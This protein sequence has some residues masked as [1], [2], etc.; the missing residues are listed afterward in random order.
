[1]SVRGRL[2]AWSTVVV[3]VLL[4]AFSTG[5]LLLARMELERQVDRQLLEDAQAVAETAPAG[6]GELDELGEH[7]V[8][9]FAV[10]QHDQL[11]FAS[12][13]WKAAGPP[14]QSLA[15]WSWSDSAG[16]PY[17]GHT[18]RMG[19]TQILVM[20]NVHS[21]A[22]TLHAMWSMWLTSIPLGLALSLIGGWFL[23]G[24]L[25]EPVRDLAARL[26]HISP[27]YLAERLVVGRRHDEF[28]TL[29]EAINETLARLEVAFTRLS[30]FTAD[31]SHQLRTPL[32]ALRS[33]GEVAL[34]AP[35]DEAKSREVIGSMLEETRR[36]S[37]LVDSLLVL[38]R[39]DA[40]QI[41]LARVPTPLSELV[42]DVVQQLR[43]LAD[44]K[45][46]TLDAHAEN[47]ETV[48]LDPATM[49]HALLNVLDNAI[50]YTP[51]GGRIAVH[52]RGRRIT[53]Q[54]SGP[55]IA[56]EHQARIFDRFYRVEATRNLVPQGSGLGLAIA[57]WVI[58][59]HG[60]RIRVESE[61]GRGAAF[62]IEL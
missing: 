32:T 54:D 24:R 8:P 11:R 62:I 47:G 10:A 25:L 9:L 34:Q 58:E 38:T 49:R 22:Q 1:M 61:A 13:G 53:V 31:A 33:V 20:R 27:E 40:Q 52:V 59:A 2:T 37:M 28:A 56:A 18:S 29:A 35:L 42:E 45:D 17:R 43:V 26:R 23:A 4:V 14:L 15:T 36:L 5:L 41:H 6:A 16:I 19:D 30:R 57:H 48:V 46:Q 50:R 55:G 3:M 12:D 21:L 7:A 44:E 39:A 51:T 60:G